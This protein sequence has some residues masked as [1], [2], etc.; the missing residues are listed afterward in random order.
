MRPSLALAAALLAGCAGLPPELQG[1]LGG[2]PPADAGVLSESEIASG[3][4]QALIT[5]SERAVARLGVADGFWLNR[6]LNIP[7]P[8]SLKKA[9]KTLR[10]LGQGRTVDEFHLSLNRA[11]EAAVPE[12]LPI[13]ANAIRAMSLADA[14]R[15]L[16]GPPTAATEYFRGKTSAALTSRFKPIVMQAT[17]AVG[18]TRKYKD[19]AGKVSRY[20][21]GYEMQDLDGY[22]TDRA[23]YGLFRA[24][25]QEEARIRTDPG[26]RTT[27][28]LRR[29]FGGS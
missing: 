13:F 18:T 22:V 21:P 26:A 8:D 6:D 24:L 29:V 20:V 17:N 14:R 5:G 27:E 4:R 2:A 10:T 28:I 25:G 19:L 9:E 11:A 15:I 1:V 23:L 7:L 3:L 16:E 12:A